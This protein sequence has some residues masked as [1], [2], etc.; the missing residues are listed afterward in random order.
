MLKLSPIPA[1]TDLT[2]RECTRLIGGILET[3]AGMTDLTTLRRAIQW[4]AESDDAWKMIDIHER[5]MRAAGLSPTKPGERFE[6]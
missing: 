5:A 2:D 3:F 6:G 1:R 4:W